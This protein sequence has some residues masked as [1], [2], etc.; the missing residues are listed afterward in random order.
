MGPQASETKKG[1]KMPDATI[2]GFTHHWE[3]TGTSSQV[4]VLIHG[5]SGA[6]IQFQPQID[7][8]SQSYRVLAVDLRGMGRSARITKLEPSSGWVD[9]LGGLLD[10]LGIEKVN[11]FGSSLGARIAL[12]FAINNPS[13]VQSL[14]L[15][16]PIVA[17]EAS[18]NAALN[19]RMGDPESLPEDQKERARLLHGEDWATVSR[20]FFQIRND[21]AMQEYLNLRE[22]AKGLPTPTLLTRGD[23][24]LDTVH[25]LPHVQ[26]LFY[27]LPNSRMWVKPAGGCFATPEGYDMVRN[28]IAAAAKVAATA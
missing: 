17:N 25:P 18:G 16:N 1:T 9:D 4:L 6:G 13:R 5:A 10:H 24:R 20:N 2:N 15:D 19:A 7:E 8:L 3:E 23:N 11:I 27:L 21:P 26:E 12:R 22:L 28:H 14:I